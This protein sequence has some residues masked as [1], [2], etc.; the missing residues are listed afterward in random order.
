MVNKLEV[1]F[2]VTGKVILGL[3]ILCLIATSVVYL[4]PAKASYQGDII[5]NV[6]G[7]V[8]PSTG[9]I[10]QIGKT[11]ILTSDV[12]GSIQVQTSNIVLEGNGHAIN[13]PSLFKA[14]IFLNHT[15]NVTVENF[16]VSGGEFGV[17]VIGQ[18]NIVKNNEVKS[19]DNGVYSIENPTGG[20][21]ISGNLNLI[22]GNNIIN[23]LV[24]MN[25]CAGIV[26]WY[27]SCEFNQI[28]ENN[29]ENCSIALLCF[30]SS[31]NTI[32]RNNFINNKEGISV[33][34]LS[35][36]NWD[37]GQ[38]G[39]YWSHYS[40]NAAYVIDD[41]NIDHY[42]LTQ[43]LDISTQITKLPPTITPSATSF[44][45]PRNAPH[46]ELIDYLL[47]ISVVLAVIVVLSILLFRRHRKTA[48]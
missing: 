32:Y 36:N 34:G 17:S 10:Q 38:T 45:P 47:P 44:Q 20:I 30:D 2:M 46:L 24:G 7:T 27:D 4:Q 28:T 33:S 13:V 29:V 6:D 43:P 12:D 48:N 42:P 31:N 19:V 11:Y 15:S 41:N 3:V 18:S 8:N 37:Y 26:G 35:N 9:V 21:L 40:G 1:R 23:C 25:L 14:G 39:N 22:K 5:I 16:F